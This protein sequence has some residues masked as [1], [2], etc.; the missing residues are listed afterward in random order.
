MILLKDYKQ[1]VVSAA[2]V[3]F[4]RRIFPLFGE[5][6]SNVLGGACHKQTAD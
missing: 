4:L 1:V 5:K 6:T 2:T 3:A